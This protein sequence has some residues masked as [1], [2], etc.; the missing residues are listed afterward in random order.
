MYIAMNEDSLAALRTNRE[1][2]DE[3]FGCYALSEAYLNG[4][5]DWDGYEVS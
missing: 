4:L 2:V 3:H 1:N 5:I